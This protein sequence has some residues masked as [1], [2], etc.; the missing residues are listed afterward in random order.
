MADLIP[1]VAANDMDKSILIL[2]VQNGQV[3]TLSI[4]PRNMPRGEEERAVR[5]CKIGGHYGFILNEE[6]ASGLNIEGEPDI[7]VC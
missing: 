2:Q 3:S 4:P 7:V 6:A 5:V 1:Y